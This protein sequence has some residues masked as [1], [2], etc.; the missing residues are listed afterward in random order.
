MTINKS[1]SILDKEELR[2]F[3]SIP[4]KNK[5]FDEGYIDSNSS[6]ISFEVKLEELSEY[7]SNNKSDEITVNN[8]KDKEVAKEFS[9]DDSFESMFNLDEL[10]EIQDENKNVLKQEDLTSKVVEKENVVEEKVTDLIKNKDEKIPEESEEKK[11]DISDN[12]IT[13]NIEEILGEEKDIEEK[14]E[15][16]EINDIDK[17][18]GVLITNNDNLKNQ[19][20]TINSKWNLKSPSIKYNPF[21]KEKLDLLKDLLADGEIPFSQWNKEL[22][23][24]KVEIANFSY[25]T[26]SLLDKMKHA[27]ELKDR[28]KE[29]QVT[30]NNQYYLWDR[31]IPMLHGL[32]YRSHSETERP[33]VKFEAVIYEHMYDIEKYYS[34]LKSIHASTE[35]VN[36]TLDNA[37]N[38]LS[39]QVTVTIPGKQI[40]R[41]EHKPI[42]GEQNDTEQYINNQEDRNINSAFIERKENKKPTKTILNE[43]ELSELE[44]FKGLNVSKRPIPK[45]IRVGWEN[46]SN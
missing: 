33:A 9:T 7:L 29:M 38:C 41:Y 27:Q 6:N 17:T 30:V 43:N 22:I 25:D 5:E 21:Y 35:M 26:V 42:Q 15:E 1:K 12:I 31:V 11:K 2:F 45:G 36:K 13:N 24:A 28:I 40:Q 10:S 39:R 8:K 46:V 14:K 20:S 18:Q 16:E 32:L 37:F 44:E 34:K 19:K 4:K 23:E 3:F